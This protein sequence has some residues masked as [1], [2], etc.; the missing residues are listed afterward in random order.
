MDPNKW[1]LLAVLG[2]ALVTVSALL[3]WG[4]WKADKNHQRSLDCLMSLMDKEAAV[5]STQ[6][7]RARDLPTPNGKAMAQREK[8][9]TRENAR[10]KLLEKLESQGTITEEDMR[11]LE[12]LS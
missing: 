3:W 12:Q 9:N 11:E 1:V 7:G 5:I 4:L 6:V 8:S 10:N 2:W